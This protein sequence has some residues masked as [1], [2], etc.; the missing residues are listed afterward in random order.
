M[1]IYGSSHGPCGVPGAPQ[2]TIKLL[3]LSEPVS[4]LQGSSQAD[5]RGL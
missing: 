1:Y 2:T 3:T 5:L 4:T